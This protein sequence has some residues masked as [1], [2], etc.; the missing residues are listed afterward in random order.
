MKL[1][2]RRL[3]LK[4]EITLKD[5]HIE[6]KNNDLNSSEEVKI[7]L[8]EID[9][10]RL[11]RIKKFDN[12]LLVVSIIFGVFFIINLFNPANYNTMEESLYPVLLFLFFASSITGFMTY[13]KSKNLIV[14]PTQNNGYIELFRSKPD[15]KEV[16]NFVEKL[17]ENINIY[18]KNK[19]GIIDLD[20]PVELQLMN[21]NLLLERKVITESEFEKLKSELKGVNPKQSKIGF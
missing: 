10:S 9:V 16:D 15:K 2:Q 21:I 12:V 18:L 19:Y 20:M 1:I 4:K 11:M 8:E 3:F 6:L 7:S 13:L 17:T 14:I 5:D